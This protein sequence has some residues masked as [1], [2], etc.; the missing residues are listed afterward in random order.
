MLGSKRNPSADNNSV[1]NNGAEAVEV[2]KRRRKK[3]WK[4]WR[5][6]VNPL[7]V[8]FLVCQIVPCEAVTVQIAYARKVWDGYLTLAGL[9]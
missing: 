3:D 2:L 5:C 4:E 6:I 8:G 9:F 1:D 7:L